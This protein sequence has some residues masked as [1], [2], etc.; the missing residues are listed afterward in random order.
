MPPVTQ[1]IDALW[2]YLCPS[3]ARWL[4]VSTI[5]V[6]SFNRLTSRHSPHGLHS[7]THKTN[8]GL[9]VPLNSP[10]LNLQPQRRRANAQHNLLHTGRDANKS[11]DS[12]KPL[13]KPKKT[14]SSRYE[15]LR[16]ASNKG[17]YLQV[18]DLVR[19]LIEEGAESPNTRLYTALLLANTSA[20]YG[21]LVK[22]QRLLQEM[23]DDGVHT[24]SAAYHAVLKVSPNRLPLKKYVAHRPPRSSPCIQTMYSDTKYSKN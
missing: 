3:F 9:Q 11:N 20:E 17:E 1:P 7:A 8:R 13:G 19:G 2:H 21:S 5:S 15:E 14:K 4:P 10:I 16:R 24:D 12:I 23:R 22:V 6:R 18:Q